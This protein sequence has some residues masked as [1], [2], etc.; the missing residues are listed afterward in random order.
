MHC[1]Q[2]FAKNFLKIII[3]EE[4]TVKVWRD[5]QRKGIKPHLWLTTNPRRGGKMLKLVAP[6]VLTIVELNIFA[7]I[8]ED[9]RT[10]SSHVSTMG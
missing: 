7:S 4:D 6:Y 10:P 1:E 2:N 5:L 9:L 8:I 3:R